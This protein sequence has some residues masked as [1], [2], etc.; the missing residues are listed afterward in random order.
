MA[1]IRPFVGYRPPPDLAPAVCCPPYDI[2]S[3]GEARNMARDNPRTFIR[4]IKPE[5]DLPPDT[6]IFSDAV[7]EK[8]TENLNAFI[9]SGSLVRD[10]A[11]CLYVYRLEYGGHV[12]TGVV[13]AASVDD[14][15]SGVIKRHELTRYD[16]EKD[17]TRFVNEQ[18]GN[19][20]PVFLTYRE[21][22]EITQ[23]IEDICSQDSP[24]TEFISADD[25][26]HTLWT[27]NDENYIDRIT[28]EF[29]EIPSLYIA[30]GHH[31]AFAASKVRQIRASSHP[32]PEAGWNYFLT[33]VFPDSQ[34]VIRD[35]NR[36]IKDLNGLSK[37][38]FLQELE[39]CFE[40][41]P[42]SQGRPEAPRQFGLFTGSQWYRLE[43]KPGTYET[44]DPVKSL[45]VSILH[46]NIISP[47]LGISDLKEESRIEFIGGT[48]GPEELERRAVSCS[49]L[50]FALFP[51]T[52]EDLMRV[53]DAGE[54]MPP[55]ST[56]FYPKPYS[57]MAVHLF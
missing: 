14:Y 43:A 6:D 41:S 30:D 38:E 45:D 33:A 32:D 37:Q 34:L 26:S 46:D 56:W 53:S 40:V 28:G 24:E 52:I 48:R 3:S 51:P 18:N 20:G 5:A 29:S 55:K 21:K 9:T 44:E 42:A 22:K 13:C 35:Y 39:S 15:D 47:I 19:A 54:I 8:A 4:V 50:A 49:G 27:V 23:I 17:R 1:I 10:P 7:Y 36:V 12:Q 11:P 2:I 31:R 16:R 25:V 57:G